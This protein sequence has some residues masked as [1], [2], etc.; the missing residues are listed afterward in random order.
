MKMNREQKI[1]VVATLL[2]GFSIYGFACAFADVVHYFLRDNPKVC[3][4]STT[5]EGKP[6]FMYLGVESE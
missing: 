1:A 3:K 5:V 6:T 2:I 4:I